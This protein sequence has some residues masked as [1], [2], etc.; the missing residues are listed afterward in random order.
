MVEPVSLDLAQRHD[1]NQGQIE[2][3][4]VRPGDQIGQ[5]IRVHAFE[6]H[7]IDLH[8]QTRRTSCRQPFEHLRQAV[9]P[10]QA[11]KLRPVERIERDIDPAHPGRSQ[12]F[13]KVAQPGAV[14]G[15]RQLFEALP[16][17]PSERAHQLDHV[18]PHQR[19]TPG[20]ADL[21]DPASDEAECELVQL[22]EGQHLLARQ[23]GLSLRHTVRATQIAAVGHRQ[24]QIADPALELVDEGLSR[25]HARI[26]PQVRHQ[27]QLAECTGR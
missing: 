23:K 7:G 10:R 6:R 20:Q 1:L 11:C 9:A 15:E 22:I 12:I 18:A 24:P 26:I 25:S 27:G 4:A 2:A 8:L 19:L 14:G 17:L 5:F 16:D 3:L 21:G 13:R